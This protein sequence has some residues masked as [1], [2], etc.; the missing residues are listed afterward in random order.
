MKYLFSISVVLVFALSSCTNIPEGMPQNPPIPTTVA[1]DLQETTPA[2][3]N[4]IEVVGGS[5]EALREFIKHWILPI[6]DVSSQDMTVYISS[7]PKDLPYDVPTPDD[8]GI[9]GSIT[10]GWV[11]YLLIFDT[12][13]SKESIHEFYA[14]N[15]ADKGWHAERTNTGQVGFVSQSHLYSSYCH[16]GNVALLTV[17]TPLTSTEKASIRLSL[18]LSPQPHD[19]DGTAV[20]RSSFD[21]RLI[22]QLEAP[23]GTRLL[24]GGVSTGDYE[25]DVTHSLQSDLSSIELLE[26][27]DQQLLASGWKMQDSGNGGGAAWSHWAFTDEQDNNWLAS[28]IIVKRS[29]DSDRLFAF[30]RMEQDK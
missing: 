2:E 21:E 27:Y 4:T 9:I 24:S 15:L 25:A 18:D 6:P 16:E 7:L 17:E 19:C 3:T 20:P 13:L 22:P 28:L 10:G 8:A 1:E 30:L 12:S 11:D 5:E 23:S 14:Q 29:A 26:F